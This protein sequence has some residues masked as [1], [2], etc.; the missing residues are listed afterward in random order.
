[1]AKRMK[2]KVVMIQ[3]YNTPYRNELFNLISDYEDIDLTLLYISKR[4]EDR[5]WKDNLQTRFKEVQV[6]CKVRQI[7]YV[8]TETRLNYIDFIKKI[9]LI[10][11]D[12][13][14][15]I[16][17]KYAILI[18]YVLFWKKVSLIHWSEATL[19]KENNINWFKKKKYLK[20]HLRLPKAFLFPGRLA[21]EYHEYCGFDLNNK[22]FYAPNSIDTLYTISEKELADKYANIQ[23]IKFLFVGS[24][25][26]QKGFHL[27]NAVFN[28]LKKGNFN[29][30]L[31]VAGD[32]Q[33]KPAE[34][35]INHGFLTKEE[36]VELYKSCHV[37]IIPSLA[38]CNP[39]SLIEAA[40]TGN[41]LLV[42]KGVG[43]YP[44]LVD[45]NGYIFE[46]DNEYDL[47]AQ[48]MKIITTNK[49]DL[50]RMGKR[51]IELASEITHQ[52]TAKSFYEA[53]KYV[54]KKT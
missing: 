23:P 35:I 5:K 3:P 34:G 49:D 6:K 28:K 8:E 45:G 14:I 17:A 54:T 46:I 13:V 18:N 4:G 22:V 37:F 43:N 15:Q 47:F 20:W 36:L 31:H 29:V 41:N 12:V 9:L 32:G 39:L 53:I 52:N 11:P 40:K 2:T 25:V 44:E 16:L 7:N 33:V 50:L 24:F 30:E 1:M 27:L 26:E 10:S 21:K 48:C 42:S 51:S 38:D 19:V